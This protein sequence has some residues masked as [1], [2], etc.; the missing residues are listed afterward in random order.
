MAKINGIEVKNVKTFLDHEGCQ[1]AQGNVYYK[2][3]KL[4]FWS[5]DSWGG[6][7][8]FDFDTSILKDEVEAY[9][10]SGRVE[11]KYKTIFDLDILMYNLLKLKDVEKEYKK[12]V[13][14][15]YQSYVRACDGYHV[16]GYYTKALLPKDVPESPF[17]TKFLKDCKKD[18]FKDWDGKV[19]VYTSM[20][21]FI[22][23]V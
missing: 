21:D 4:G 3:K 6:P 12:C 11:E 2:G 19:E 5:Q 9:K 8:N 23:E 20:D 15:G 16:S 17:H 22:I 18:F 7:D 1:I 13:K 14:K 10:N